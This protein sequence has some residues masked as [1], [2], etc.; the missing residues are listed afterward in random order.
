MTT[1]FVHVPTYLPI[2]RTVPW[3]LIVCLSQ[4]LSFSRSSTLFWGEIAP[5]Y[6]NFVIWIEIDNQRTYSPRSWMIG[7]GCGK[8]S[9]PS[10]GPSPEISKLE[11]RERQSLSGGK[12]ENVSISH[13]ACCVEEAWMSTY[14]K[15]AESRRDKRWESSCNIRVFNFSYS[16]SLAAG[17]LNPLHL[18]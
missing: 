11:Q 18:K 14:R 1:L 9:R 7:S 6:L 15:Y 10:Q 17:L 8:G 12:Y 13:I 4:H 16:Q 3:T 2:Y 5:L